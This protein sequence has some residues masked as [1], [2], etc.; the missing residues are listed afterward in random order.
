MSIDATR[1]VRSLRAHGRNVENGSLLPDSSV[2]SLP[3]NSKR[4]ANI[5][6]NDC[7]SVCNECK[8]A[9]RTFCDGSDGNFYC[10][11]CWFEF[12]GNVPRGCESPLL[13]SSRADIAAVGSQK[14]SDGSSK[15]M[16]IPL[17]CIGLANTEKSSYGRSP[18]G[19]RAETAASMN[20][21]V[22]DSTP[23]IENSKHANGCAVSLGF[24]RR[25]KS[26]SI[27]VVS[28]GA[29]ALATRPSEPYVLNR[30]SDSIGHVKSSDEI[31]VSLLPED[32]PLNHI[33][34]RDVKYDPRENSLFH[35]R[36][37]SAGKRIPFQ[38]TVFACGGSKN[39]AEV[40]ARACYM[41][42]EQGWSKTDVTR[43]RGEC[44][45]RLS[46]GLKHGH[47]LPSSKVQ[48]RRV[49]DSSQSQ[50]QSLVD[51]DH[52]PSKQQRC[53]S[54]A[55]ISKPLE[56]HDRPPQCTHSARETERRQM[57]G[58]ATRVDCGNL[59]P[60][61]RAPGTQAAKVVVRT[62]P[63]RSSGQPPSFVSSNY[64]RCLL[65]NSAASLSSGA[66]E[67]VPCDQT[68]HLERQV[69]NVATSD[70]ATATTS[71]TRCHASARLEPSA[72]ASS[73]KNILHPQEHNH[74]EK[75]LRL[76]QSGL[77]HIP[78]TRD[79]SDVEKKHRSHQTFT[80]YFVQ[81]AHRHPE[82]HRQSKQAP[83]PP[84]PPPPPLSEPESQHGENS[85][86]V[87]QFIPE[88]PVLARSE[89]R[90]SLTTPQL[91]EEIPTPCLSLP[92]PQL[93]PPASMPKRAEANLE[94]PT[95]QLP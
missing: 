64:L 22:S 86:P 28:F 13:A 90:H 35:F 46:H 17:D 58:Q 82:M 16:N 61:A 50:G 1:S 94:E 69:A 65:D 71:R 26:S 19:S 45:A 89:L 60:I 39:A 75:K 62:A 95:P 8:A 57:G 68:M 91:S 25:D 12:Y 63:V 81:P 44:Y 56:Q 74:A 78:R 53:E 40:I 11:K 20:R 10:S 15:Y 70:G 9:G 18:S 7:S 21:R 51:H 42:F 54:R 73:A 93:F 47:R 32:A 92:T 49:S 80:D 79:K 31:P 33:S 88:A 72:L 3:Y 43:F 14:A 2:H 6:L 23:A 41:K 24:D 76:Q 66:W 67:I 29:G 5:H 48:K 38:V 30:P 27:G 83:P 34:R 85:Q 55:P 84:P 52:R 87:P 37:K 59:E 36:F 77:D 4:D